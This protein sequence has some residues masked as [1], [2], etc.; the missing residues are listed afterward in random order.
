LDICTSELVGHRQSE[1][2][3]SCPAGWSFEAR[4]HHHSTEVKNKIYHVTET[5]NVND[6]EVRTERM[7]LSHTI[8]LTRAIVANNRNNF[9][10]AANK[11]IDHI[12]EEE[13]ISVSRELMIFTSV[14]RENS[15]RVIWVH[16]HCAN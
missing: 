3:K 8:Y 2:E 1:N 15:L 5:W 9:D 14:K 6:S 13:L 11:P 7:R 10:F 12:Q 16:N 4:D